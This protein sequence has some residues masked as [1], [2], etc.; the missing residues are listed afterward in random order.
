MGLFTT[1][2][3]LFKSARGLLIFI[4]VLFVLILISFM[5]G[6]DQSSKTTSSL[7][8]TPTIVT[9]KNEEETSKYPLHSDIIATMFWVGEKATSANDYIPNESSAWNTNWMDD[10]G[11]IDNPYTRNGYYPEGFVP[12]ENPFYFA[13]PYDDMGEFGRKE[14]AQQI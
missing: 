7:T 14:N 9:D 8:P 11:G 6:K 13:L 2:F 5:T 3:K 10:Y 1:I 4:C 12:K